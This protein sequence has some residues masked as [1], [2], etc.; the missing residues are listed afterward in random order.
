MLEQSFP[1]RW[2]FQRSGLQ[3]QQPYHRTNN[4]SSDFLNTQFYLNRFEI[5]PRFFQSF[6][7]IQLNDFKNPIHKNKDGHYLYAY[8]KYKQ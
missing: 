7:K 8:Q 2:F 4:I 5:S 6:K 1:T 3:P